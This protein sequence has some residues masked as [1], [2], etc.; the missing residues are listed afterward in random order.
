MRILLV[1]DDPAI[2][3][4]LL[5]GLQE[6]QHAVELIEEGT[7]AE[8]RGY[9]DEYDA[10][11]LDVM[12]P[13]RTGFELCAR[14]RTDGVDT[15]IL[16]LTAKDG[17]DA[18]VR[19][20][21]A[22][23]DDYL[24]KPFSFAEL[25]ARLRAIGRRGRTKALSATL[26]YGPIALDERDRVVTVCDARMDLTATEYRV[27][28]LFLHRPETIVSREQLADRVWGGELDPASNVVE[29][30]IG[31]VRKKLQAH[32]ERPLVHTLRGLGYM[33]NVEPPA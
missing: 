2:S 29:V 11:V 27:L 13:G 6:E 15:P 1:E 10:I 16:M 20:L 31:Y 17:V 19:G 26:R 28:E 8:A 14:W 9:S 7:E 12:L 3:S 22:G 4:F 25:L 24:A 23:A 32:Y 18:R 33:L 5:K 30:Y 21:D